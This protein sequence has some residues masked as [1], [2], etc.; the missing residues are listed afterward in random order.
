MRAYRLTAPGNLQMVEVPEPT[1]A[2]GEA[3]IQV[4]ACGVCGTDLHMKQ[5]GHESW[6]G[7][8]ITLGHEIV[9]KIVQL[10]ANY[11]GPLMVDDCVVVDPQIVCGACYYCRRGRLNLC[12]SLEHIGLSIDGGF[13]ERMAVPVRNLYRIPAGVSPDD[14]W[15]MALVEPV[16]TC[17]AGMN[18]VNPRP[19]ES[20]AVVGLGFFGQVYLQ[21]ARLW[22]VQ[23]VLGFDPL[24]ER[25]ETA[26]QLGT[27]LVFDPA[28]RSTV[29]H[30]VLHGQGAQV[31][32]DAAG[33]PDAAQTCVDLASKTGRLLV[34]G[35]RSEPVQVDWYQI[36]LKEL[37]VL[38]SRSSNHAWEQ[39]LLLVAHK[40]LRFNTLIT[41]YLFSEIER[42]FADAEQKRVFKPIV[43]ISDLELAPSETERMII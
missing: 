26:Q 32:I 37:T 8:P 39:S 27:P 29:F 2:E 12:D 10:P 4:I 33:S 40:R 23:T 3:L 31:V 42:A 17:V 16:A 34:F 20:V 9:G 13:T 11:Q 28:E 43:A 25:R 30:E 24:P 36:L 6:Q 38:G 14:R 22:G 19:D 7:N 35:Y 5:R 1:P 21:L 18:L 41:P 15:R